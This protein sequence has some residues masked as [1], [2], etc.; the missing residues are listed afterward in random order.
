MIPALSPFHLNQ[1][2]RE[3]WSEYDAYVLAI[4]EPA[5]KSD[6]YTP[7]I[8]KAP[9]ITQEVIAVNGYVEY[10]LKMTPGALWIGYVFPASFELTEIVFQ[11]T[12]TGLDH[13]RYSDPVPWYI[14]SNGKLDM[15]TLQEP[16]PIVNP[17]LLIVEFWNVS[18]EQLRTQLQFLALEPKA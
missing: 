4:L 12:D 17:G 5:L 11:V 16:Y 6:C 7:K 15:P 3:L 9:D 14:A 18:G 2:T 8:Y 13:R 1:Y 10:G